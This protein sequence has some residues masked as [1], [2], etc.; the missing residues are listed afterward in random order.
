M[1]WTVKAVS[2]LAGVSIR[3]LHHYDA[4]GLLKPSAVSEAGYRLYSQADLERLQQ[5]VFFRELEVSLHDIKA[6]LADPGFDRKDALIHQRRIL[7]ERKTRL[8]Q[9]VKTIDR[10]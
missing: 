1:A 6:I 3:A 4:I 2:E 10:T 9:M 8:H 7:L 5:I